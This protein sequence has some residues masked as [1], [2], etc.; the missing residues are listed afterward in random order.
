MAPQLAEVPPERT[1][2]ALFSEGTEA[3]RRGDRA[4]AMRIY[5]ELLAKHPGA[6]EANATRLALGRLA[7]DTGDSARALG[8]F[9]QY[10]GSGESTLREEAMAGRARALQRLGR[11]TDE[12]AAWTTLLQSYPTTIH[13]ERATARIEEL[14]HR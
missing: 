13:R 9:E 6:A 7:L 11:E 12:R 10:L 4:T 5:G 2:V 8:L 1:A 14:G 3:R